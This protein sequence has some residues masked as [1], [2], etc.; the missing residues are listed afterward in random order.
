MTWRRSLHCR[1]AASYVRPHFDQPT[2]RHLSLARQWRHNLHLIAQHELRLRLN[3]HQV[4]EFTFTRGANGD[5]H[6]L[7]AM[8]AFTSW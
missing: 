3:S 4:Q 8:I 2:Q 1:N 6:F 7:R 5:V